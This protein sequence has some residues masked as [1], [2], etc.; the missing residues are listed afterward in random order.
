MAEHLEEGSRG[1][2]RDELD[3]KIHEWHSSGPEETRDL[4]EYLGWSWDEYATWIE[5]GIQPK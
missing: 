5:S 4:H 1:Y 2:S 3:D